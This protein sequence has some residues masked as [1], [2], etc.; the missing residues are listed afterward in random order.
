MSTI[1]DTAKRWLRALTIST[2]LLA[3]GV[4]ETAAITQEQALLTFIDDT[5]SGIVLDRSGY[6]RDARDNNK[7]IVFD[8]GPQTPSRD[9]RDDEDDCVWKKSRERNGQIVYSVV[10]HPATGGECCVV[11]DFAVAADVA[12]LRANGLHISTVTAP[13]APTNPSSLGVNSSN[14]DGCDEPQ[15]ES[16]SNTPD[17]TTPP[18]TQPP[19]TQPPQT[20]PPATQPPVLPPDGCEPSCP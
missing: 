18:E 11:D 9:F 12:R 10:A 16:T 2:P 14:N 13:V 20:Q 5:K 1:K 15:S 6:A 17:P 8:Q 4:Q 3:G 7:Y 19:Q